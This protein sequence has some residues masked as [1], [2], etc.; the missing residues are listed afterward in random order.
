N[1]GDLVSLCESLDLGLHAAEILVIHRLQSVKDQFPATIGLQLNMP[2][3]QVDAHRDGISVPKTLEFIDVIDL[4]SDEELEC[5]SPG[6]HRGWEDRR[7]SCRR[8]RTAAGEAVG[9]TLSAAD[10]DKL[11]LLA[12]YRN[13][14]FR[15]P[16]PV[17][18]VPEEIVNGFPALERLVEG[19]LGSSRS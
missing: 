17:R 18:V 13:R 4:L 3:P 19:L 10:Q 14:L 2:E 15:S 9:L 1:A 8:S 7:F 16:P 12:A 6:L 11:L 5:V